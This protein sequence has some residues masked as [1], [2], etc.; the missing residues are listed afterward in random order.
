MWAGSVD[1]KCLMKNIG[2]AINFPLTVARFGAK[3][4]IRSLDWI[5]YS[6]VDIR[7]FE[8]FDQKKI[9]ALIPFMID[10]VGCGHVTKSA[11]IGRMCLCEH[12]ECVSSLRVVGQMLS[13]IALAMFIKLPNAI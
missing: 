1:W 5:G 2:R 3:E 11:P 12:G 8:R 9:Q 10:K 4:D 6:G 13:A 7:L